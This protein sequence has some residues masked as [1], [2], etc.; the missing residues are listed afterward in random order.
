[1][2][3]E[4]RRGSKFAM[5]ATAAATEIHEAEFRLSDGTWVMPRVPLADLSNWERWIGSLRVEALKLSNLVLI[6][7]QDSDNPAILDDA[8]GQLGRNLHRVYRLL[9]LRSGVECGGADLLLGSCVDS[10][11]AV[12]Q[13]SQLPKFHQSK[14]YLR[15]PITAE[16]L[17]EAVALRCGLL[18]IEAEEHHFARAITGMNVLFDGL[19]ETA[20]ERI[21]QFVRASGARKF[22]H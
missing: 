10:Q 4:F 17:E 12:R 8:H 21:H 18:E 11:P 7:D 5:L 2:S 19:K 14:G 15:A 20:H 22:G 9:H 6:A 1:M 3:Y 16:W 13:L